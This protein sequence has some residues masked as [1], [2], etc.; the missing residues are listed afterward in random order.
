MI[1]LACEGHLR[2]RCLIGW[3]LDVLTPA[4]LERGPTGHWEVITGHQNAPHEAASRL[5]PK[6]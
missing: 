5:D 6:P 3:L 4:K 1:P 2:P